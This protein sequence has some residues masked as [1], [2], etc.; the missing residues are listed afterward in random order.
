MKSHES[1]QLLGEVLETAETLIKRGEEGGLWG[2]SHGVTTPVPTPAPT[3]LQGVANMKLSIFFSAVRS[4]MLSKTT[5][6]KLKELESRPTA[7]GAG[8]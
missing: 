4:I 5:V 8:C 3:C 1:G 7:S 6:D 2:F